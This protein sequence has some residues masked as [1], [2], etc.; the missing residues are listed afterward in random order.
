MGM[1]MG[2]GMGTARNTLP[3]PDWHLAGL[4]SP[5]AV[6]GAAICIGLTVALASG[7]LLGPG[8]AAVAGAAFV[9]LIIWCL[10]EPRTDRTLAV[11]ALYIGLLDAYLKLSTGVAEFAILRDVLLWAIAA[12]ALWRAADRKES[13]SLPPLSGLVIAFALVVLAELFNPAAPG[14]LQGLA[15]VRQHIEF[16]P[17][18][19]LAYAFLRTERQLKGLLLI[20][21]VCA[22][23]SGVA[24]CVQS[25]LTP[26]EFASWG[27]GYSDQILSKGQYQGAGRT[28]T[29]ALGEGV[30]RP[31]GL[32]TD[33][34]AGA[35]AA[36]AGLP[37]LL[38][39]FLLGSTRLRIGL[40]LLAPG[41]VLGVAT[42]GGRGALIATVISLASFLLFAAV[43]RKAAAGVGLVSVTVLV[44]YLVFVAIEPVNSVAERNRSIASPT[45]VFSSY[46]AERADSLGLAPRYASEFPF[47]LGVGWTGSA[48]FNSVLG[49]GSPNGAESSSNLPELDAE[50]QWNYL[51]IETGILGL[52]IYL[53]LIGQILLRAAS[54][55]RGVEENG[56]RLS[57]AAIAAPLSALLVVGFSG[58]TSPLLVWLAAG[59]F[60]YWMFGAGREL[61][62]DLP[63]AALHELP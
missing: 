18:F 50:T 11:F 12:G 16:I 43:S 20:F 44:G 59:V 48:A 19:F 22:S 47:G 53:L 26:A 7:R 58:I 29:N 10:A 56:I 32:G 42:S 34:G 62:G 30:V 41:I 57:L 36:V 17:L 35:M 63:S 23:A 9:L 38:A 2:M 5:L 8:I 51:L 3:R 15:G 61:T 39:L 33:A 24:S 54:G 25:T 60:A 27:P 31:F 28:S 52:I 55:L 45:K 37:A 13:L 46:S 6:A 49:S 1:G 14:L 21:V 40:L 4:T